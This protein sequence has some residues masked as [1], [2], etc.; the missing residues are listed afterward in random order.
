ML[1]ADVAHFLLDTDGGG[2]VTVD[3]HALQLYEKAALLLSRQRQGSFERL[4]RKRR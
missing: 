4:A 3:S 2:I 1:V